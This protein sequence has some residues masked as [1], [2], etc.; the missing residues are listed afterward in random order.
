MFPKGGLSNFECIP[1]LGEGS[2]TALFVFDNNRSRV[3]T[4]PEY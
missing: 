4:S 1:R 3:I 2:L